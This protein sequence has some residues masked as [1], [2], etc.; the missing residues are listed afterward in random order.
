[1][2]LFDR[3]LLV[4]SDECVRTEGLDWPK[5]VWLLDARR[6]D[7]LV[8]IGTLPLPPMEDYAIGGRYGAIICTKT[9]LAHRSSPA[10]WF[11]VPTSAVACVCMTSRIRFSRAKWHRIFHPRRTDHR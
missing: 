11:S 4:V 7:N 3:D 8:S 10:L 1:M 9:G 6:E 2:P 5:L